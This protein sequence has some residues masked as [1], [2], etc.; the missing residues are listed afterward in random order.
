MRS[1][2]RE[3]VNRIEEIDTLNRRFRDLSEI[4]EER[5]IT[6]I[7]LETKNGN[8]SDDLRASER[9]SREHRTTI[10]RMLAELEMLREHLAREKQISRRL[11]EK[12][13]KLTGHI[14]AFETRI[15]RSQAYRRD[16]ARGRRRCRYRERPYRFHS[17]IGA[18]PSG[19]GEQRER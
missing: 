4:A 12:Y 17:G 18:A 2:H 8:L 14:S 9:S 19:P 3:L 13:V 15:R 16:R 7:A 6:I 11:D 5:Q 10:E 1:T